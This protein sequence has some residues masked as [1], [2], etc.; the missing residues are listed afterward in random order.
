MLG[1]CATSF[2]I[3]FVSHSRMTRTQTE[4]LCHYL[5]VHVINLHTKESQRLEHTP[6]MCVSVIQ[7]CLCNQNLS[8]MG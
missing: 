2:Q 5:S 7:M 3:P 1:F 8:K 4:I 6:N